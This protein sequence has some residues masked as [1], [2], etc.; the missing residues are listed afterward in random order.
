VLVYGYLLIAALA[1]VTRVWTTLFMCRHTVDGQGFTLRADKMD[2]TTS[3]VGLVKAS[4]YEL[5]S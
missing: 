4:I 1:F 3:N 5:I 2:G